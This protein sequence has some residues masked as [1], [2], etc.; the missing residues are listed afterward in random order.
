M[1]RADAISKAKAQKEAFVVWLQIESDINDSGKQSKNGP[2][3]LYVRYTIFEPATAR[4][5]QWGRTHQQIYKVGR[6]GVST[7]TSSKNSPLY[8][9]YALK[10]SAKEAAERILEAFEIKIRDDRRWLQ[11]RER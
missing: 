9:E 7:P 11:N 3:E 2:D 10:Q 5:K 1:T 6:G 8:S 4:I